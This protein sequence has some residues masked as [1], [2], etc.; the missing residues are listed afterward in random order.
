[1]IASLDGTVAA[2]ALDSLVVEVGGVGY[3]VYAAPSVLAAA[4]ASSQISQYVKHYGLVLL[5]NYR[6]FL[7]LQ[8]NESGASVALECFQLAPTEAAFWSGAAHPHK[9]A[10]ALEERLSE[11]CV[12]RGLRDK[13][14]VHR[15]SAASCWAQAGDFY[16]AIALCD[17][18][19]TRTD[20]PEP[21]R[22]RV[23]DYVHTL[24]ARRAQWYAELALKE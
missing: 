20:L 4:A 3:R 9:T 8:R 12:A 23:S 7:L 5:T 18:L 6:G 16:D 11:R 14:R 21:V 13:A 1:M 2:I 17:E 10:A 22:R 15:F 24:R 19:L